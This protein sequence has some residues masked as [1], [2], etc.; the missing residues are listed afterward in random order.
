M[1][2]ALFEDDE[3]LTRSF[4]TRQEVWKAAERAGLVVPGADGELILDDH[5]EIKPC[6]SHPEEAV[7]P[8]SDFIFS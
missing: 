4:P 7:D 3:R 8:G 6:E 2:Y 1:P 5:F